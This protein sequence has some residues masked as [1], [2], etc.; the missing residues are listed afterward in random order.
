MP[1]SKNMSYEITTLA[2]CPTTGLGGPQL[3]TTTHPS[4]TGA[5]AEYSNIGPSYATIHLRRQ[6]QPMSGVSQTARISERYN[7]SEAYLA[8]PVPA[9]RHNDGGAWHTTSS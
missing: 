5:A 9:A 6:P 3:A 2:N 8:V 7:F 1:V 4:E